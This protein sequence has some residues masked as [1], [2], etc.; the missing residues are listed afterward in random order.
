MIGDP[1]L[2]SKY[3]REGDRYDDS[4][5]AIRRT[6][7]IDG[8]ER[9]TIVRIGVDFIG[10]TIIPGIGIKSPDPENLVCL[11]D[12][13]FLIYNNQN[14]PVKHITV[15]GT[16]TEIQFDKNGL[17]RIDLVS[18]S[19]IILSK[20]GEHISRA[21]DEGKVEEIKKQVMLDDE[22]TKDIEPLT[23]MLIEAL[24]NTQ[25]K[26]DYNFEDNKTSYEMYT[27]ITEEKVT[28]KIKSI[29]AVKK[30][31]E[32]ELKGTMFQIT[33][34]DKFVAS[35]LE[36]TNGAASK[37]YLYFTPSKEV[38]DF[39]ATEEGKKLLEAEEGKDPTIQ[40]VGEGESLRLRFEVKNCTFSGAAGFHVEAQGDL[41][42]EC[43]GGA[44][45]LSVGNRSFIE[46][47]KVL[48]KEGQKKTTAN[49]YNITLNPDFLTKVRKN[50][51]G[52]STVKSTQ[53]KTAE[54]KEDDF[55]KNMPVD[56]LISLVNLQ[57][58]AGA[59]GIKTY[60]DGELKIL[61][62][63][64]PTTGEKQSKHDQAVF[65]VKHN[66]K[67][68]VLH[69]GALQELRDGVDYWH[70]SRQRTKKALEISPLKSS[71]GQSLLIPFKLG[72][73]DEATS[74]KVEEIVAFL[75][76]SADKAKSGA[77]TG[78]A[79]FANASLHSTKSVAE[80]SYAIKGLEPVKEKIY[81][82][83][84]ETE[85]TTQTDQ[86]QT[87]TTNDNVK[88]DKPKH[89]M[90][91]AAGFWNTISSGLFFAMFF[92]ILACAFGLGVVAM[93][94][95]IAFAA[96]GM[97]TKGIS[98]V[99]G[100]GPLND[101][102]KDVAKTKAEKA[103][104]KINEKA[105]ERKN[106]KYNDKVKAVEKIDERISELEKKYAD[107][108][109]NH[110]ET[111]SEAQKVAQQ[112]KKLKSKRAKAQSKKDKYIEKLSP[113][114]ILSTIGARPN[115]DML[116]LTTTRSGFEEK[117]DLYDGMIHGILAEPLDTITIDQ[118]REKGRAMAA[119]NSA[120]N[121]QQFYGTQYEDVLNASSVR[122]VK[123]LTNGER[124]SIWDAVSQLDEKYG[125]KK[126]AEY[127]QKFVEHDRI[128]YKQKVKKEELTPDEEKFA[129]EFEKELKT[130]QADLGKTAYAEWSKYIRTEAR[131]KYEDISTKFGIT[132]VDTIS[133]IWGHQDK[134]E[135]LS[136][137]E[138]DKTITDKEK[139]EL[140]AS[141]KFVEDIQ[142]VLAETYPLEEE[143]AL[144]IAEAGD[145]AQLVQSIEMKY[146]DSNYVA[147]VKKK[148]ARERY[149]ELVKLLDPTVSHNPATNPITKKTLALD[150]YIYML[151]H[152]EILQEEIITVL[153]KGPVELN[154]YNV[155]KEEKIKQTKTREAAEK[156]ATRTTKA[157][158]SI[159]QTLEEQ[160]QQIEENIAT[161]SKKGKDL[162]KDERE[163][164]EIL[165][166]Q[167]QQVA[168]AIQKKKFEEA[169]DKDFEEYC[170]KNKISKSKQKELKQKA[171]ALYK[172]KAGKG[173]VNKAIDKEMF[174][175]VI[176]EVGHIQ[177]HE[178]EAFEE[179]I[180]REQ[181]EI[182]IE[183][184]SKEKT[185][186]KAPK[187]VTATPTRRRR[188][189]TA[190][191]EATPTVESVYGEGETPKTAKP[192]D[193]ESTTEITNPE[194][195][196]RKNAKNKGKSK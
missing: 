120:G 126:N 190:T 170:K 67:N 140:A 161:L 31:T 48:T 38:L 45:V 18:G 23:V 39:L 10:C 53:A 143:K 124:V 123:E 174:K 176:A 43:N 159:P 95:A 115:V 106:K 2:G 156:P 192:E 149:K 110:L 99:G 142:A 58:T 173:F 46:K 15:N 3:F 179:P 50:A 113:M 196:K 57:G 76:P 136:K 98:Y 29:V 111:S 75:Q 177:P 25:K 133:S 54:V 96:A 186:E 193:Y 36:E 85:K 194:K 148:Y 122:F 8:V 6:E 104:D 52:Y 125:G 92:S 14:Q 77:K 83:E 119:A 22:N 150:K 127:T 167:K 102:A 180:I 130:I 66:G 12:G 17:A 44:S 68:F 131:N 78:L 118:R 20:D 189:A 93:P 182:D 116:D 13:S 163:L 34:D 191:A 30:F 158:Q 87:T 21:D 60:N 181:L 27:S 73:K 129:K 91:K 100:F 79:N 84:K 61:S 145:D 112:L 74:K 94:L 139:E 138:K 183:E 26:V 24:K 134:V 41:K 105:N 35:L 121:P 152:E 16:E 169:F 70:D 42:Y 187:P 184:A 175:S 147:S 59:N 117:Q 40:T 162:T 81:E 153:P 107:Y 171:L 165:K 55:I 71:P 141:R 90:K 11:N 56:L 65:F 166:K 69:D 47:V 157:P 5:S 64:L 154:A 178:E 137:K 97:V 88:N 89:D 168:K 109:K 7:K 62:C 63:T 151:E 164:L 135:K 195:R 9:T 33:R 146:A 82:K 128:R 1:I 185:G 114:Q 103:K 19:D 28:T 49:G 132:G 86:K 32:E 80:A 101:V 160:I 72:T 144:A 51:N 172:Q 37:K 108:K 4:I 155:V 188:T